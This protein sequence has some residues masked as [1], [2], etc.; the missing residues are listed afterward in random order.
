MHCQKGEEQ[1]F[2]FLDHNS[3]YTTTAHILSFPPSTSLFFFQKPNIT[4]QHSLQLKHLP[5]DL[6]KMNLLHYSKPKSPWRRGECL[7]FPAYVT[8]FHE[9]FHSF[10][11]WS[12]VNHPLLSSQ[13]CSNILLKLGLNLTAAGIGVSC[14][15]GD[16]T[17]F[18]LGFHKYKHRCC[19]GYGTIMAWGLC[20]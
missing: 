17:C 7:I 5:T 20:L 6:L 2:F 3:L 16:S 15:Y 1:F 8:L 13:Y 18:S 4:H 19:L 9:P 11:V 12:A 14:P 10:S